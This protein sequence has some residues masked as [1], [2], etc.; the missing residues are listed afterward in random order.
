MSV[1]IR[2][3]AER[4]LGHAV[5]SAAVRTRT[6]LVYDPYLAGRSVERIEGIAQAAGG[7]EVVWRAIVKR[8]AGP[9]LRAGRRELAAYRDL[10]TPAGGQ[11]GLR[12]PRLLAWSDE[13]GHVE[14]WLEELGDT[15][16][17]RWPAGRFA[18]A[19]RHI[20]TWDA[21]AARRGLP[22][23]FDAEDEWAERHGQPHLV[24]EALAEVEAMVGRSGALETGE[25]MDDHG[26]ARTRRLIASTSERIARLATFARTPLHHDLVR[27]NLFAVNEASTVAIDWENVGRGPLGVDLAPLVIGSVRRG[28]ASSDDLAA[29]EAGV[30]T[31]YSLGLRAAGVGVRHDIDEAYRLAV[32]L[33]WHVVLG[34]IRTAVT[35]GSA[36]FRG[37]RLD[38]PRTEAL[39]HLVALSR[40]ILAVAEG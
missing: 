34:T 30:L 32:G 7:E 29:I 25:M 20:G 11:V 17:G 36:G 22:R 6:P 13:S 39:R 19:A 15:Y 28:E 16:G 9:G 37:S 33:R 21:D 14:I 23:D 12:A 38:E 40:H 31:G 18:I 3:A 35:P 5:A 2:Q 27:S 10:L 24:R 8:T 4:A 26:L 1:D